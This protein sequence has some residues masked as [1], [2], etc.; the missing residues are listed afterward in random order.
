MLK[1]VKLVIMLSPKEKQMLDSI[2][3]VLGSGMS[4]MIRETIR[5]K[6]TKIFPYYSV[7]QL[8]KVKEEKQ[9]E[10]NKLITVEQYCEL[11]GGKIRKENGTNRCAFQVNPPTRFS[12]DG[13]WRS[14][15]LDKKFIDDYFK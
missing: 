6:Y 15:P 3:D 2:C 7:R 8:N 9:E 10:E 11:K 14:V 13:T 12:P 1:T 4:E 5:N